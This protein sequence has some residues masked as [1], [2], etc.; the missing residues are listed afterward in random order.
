LAEVDLIIKS[1]KLPM[2]IWGNSSEELG[3][4]SPD[5]SVSFGLTQGDRC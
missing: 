2:D 4:Y 5:S 1:G 3:Y